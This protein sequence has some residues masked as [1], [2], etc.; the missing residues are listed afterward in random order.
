[1]HCITRQL[2]N[3]FIWFRSVLRRR[4]CERLLLIL[5]ILSPYSLLAQSS[6]EN[7]SEEEFPA[8]IQMSEGN[9]AIPAPQM[10]MSPG[11][12]FL[13]LRGALVYGSKVIQPS[14][15]Q[16]AR[17]EIPFVVRN[18]SSQSGQDGPIGT[19]PRE[20][21]VSDSVANIAFIDNQAI[22]ETGSKASTVNWIFTSECSPS[23][24]R[25]FPLE[26]LKIKKG[27]SGN[28]YLD[29]SDQIGWD[30]F[31]EFLER[32]LKITGGKIIK[33]LPVGPDIIITIEIN[34]CRLDLICEDDFPP[35]IT[36]WLGSN[37]LEGDQLL[38]ELYKDFLSRKSI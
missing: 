35:D 33:E 14:M 7:F 23:N 10:C 25:S 26:A 20:N 12:L 9:E 29:L 27:K 18:F 36:V 6:L 22:I 32:F 17:R 19:I 8:V 13:R 30:G 1:M 2:R 16:S 15:T 21:L 24:G 3:R 11:A 31:S 4:G 37:S 34:G 38:R 28:L 5:G